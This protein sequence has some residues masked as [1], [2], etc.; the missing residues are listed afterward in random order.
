MK[1]MFLGQAGFLIEGNGTRFII[2][3]YLSNFVVDSGIGNAKL[4]S[5]EF[6]AP[7][8]TD[9]LCDIDTAFITHDHADH[10]DPTTLIP[11]LMNNP[12]CKVIC[13][14]TVFNVLIKL[15]ISHKRLC[16]PPVGM[17]QKEGSLSYS[18]IP[19]AHYLLD[20]NPETGESP[21]FGYVI[22]FDGVVIYHSGDTVL[23]DGLLRTLRHAAS[24]IDIACLPVNGRDEKREALGIIGNLQPEEAAKLAHSL[25]ANFLIPM[26]NDLFKINR[27]DPE[28]VNNHIT[29][30]FTGQKVKW[31]QPGDVFHYP[32]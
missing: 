29:K 27:L 23:Y 10:C 3:P 26:H 4:F 2:D 6:P 7:I 8:Q 30:H 18:A 12:K 17:G 19:S 32:R 24:H 13:P 15:G 16:V 1:I 22:E 20:L 25:G 5:R 9:K 14:Y 21:Y 11:L 28:I 31:L